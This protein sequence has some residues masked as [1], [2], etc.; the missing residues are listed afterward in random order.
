MTSR[1]RKQTASSP[2]A[3]GL[4]PRGNRRKYSD[5]ATQTGRRLLAGRGQALEPGFRAPIRRRAGP[6]EMAESPSGRARLLYNRT[7]HEW[8][9]RLVSSGGPSGEA[10]PK[11]SRILR[12]KRA[13]PLCRAGDDRVRW[14][15]DANAEPPAVHHER[16]P[17]PTRDR[18]LAMILAPEL[19][20]QIRIAGGR[21]ASGDVGYFGT[22]GGLS[23][24]MRSKRRPVEMDVDDAPAF[25]VITAT[26]SSEQGRS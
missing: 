6:R 25:D 24:V 16:R 1:T 10:L 23:Q 4:G 14:V 2:C 7:S 21:R 17:R 9:R 5:G 15:N 18:M 11:T 19:L 26:A 22:R 12:G 13:A 8:V 20:P 3:N